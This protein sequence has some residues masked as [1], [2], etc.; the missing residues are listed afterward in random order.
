MSAAGL[1]H[2]LISVHVFVSCLY[3]INKN[4]EI[5]VISIAI[6]MKV[7]FYAVLPGNELR[8]FC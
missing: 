1:Y 6:Q 5:F 4:V 3:N 7:Q 8:A 2:T